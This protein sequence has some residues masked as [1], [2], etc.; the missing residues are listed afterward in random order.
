MESSATQQSADFALNFACTSFVSP[1]SAI[2]KS[3]VRAPSDA[4]EEW[5]EHNTI[6][7]AERLVEYQ[8]RM[9]DVASAYL[10]DE[11]S[12][13]VVFDVYWDFAAESM[14]SE[15]FLSQFGVISDEAEF[16]IQSIRSDI[17]AKAV[18]YAKTRDMSAIDREDKTKEFLDYAI[19]RVAAVSEFF[20]EV[21][22]RVRIAVQENTEDAAYAKKT[23]NKLEK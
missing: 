4:L 20:K 5:R 17:T 3:E 11:V 2:E 13:Q 15:S 16:A 1:F 18:D 6:K 9:T 10:H 23:A 14:T 7:S 22:E 12:E 21:S 8:G 19:P